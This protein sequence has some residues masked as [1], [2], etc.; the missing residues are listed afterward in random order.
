M[1]HGMGLV[2]NEDISRFNKNVMQEELEKL[3]EYV[4]NRM[5]EINERLTYNIRSERNETLAEL[6]LIY[7]KLDILAKQSHHALVY[8]NVMGFQP[9]EDHKRL[10]KPFGTDE[11]EPYTFDTLTSMRNVDSSVN[12][13]VIILEE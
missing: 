3:S 7:D 5:E 9:P 11:N 4:V 10:M 13:N 2:E 12:V 1:R 6:E 8:G